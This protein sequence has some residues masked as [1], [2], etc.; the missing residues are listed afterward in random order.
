MDRH[1]DVDVTMTGRS[2]LG[3]GGLHERI[4]WSKF[5]N[6][7]F[8]LLDLFP[9]DFTL[10]LCA[11]LFV[12][13]TSFRPLTGVL[14]SNAAIRQSMLNIMNAC[15]QGLIPFQIGI[16]GAGSMGSEMAQ[17]FA[18]KGLV[19]SVFDVASAN[20]DALMNNLQTTDKVTPDVHERIHSFKDYK[21]F[22]D[23]LGG[24]DTKK[25]F[26]LSIK[27][28]SPADEVIKSLKEWLSSGDVILD[29]GNEWYRSTERRQEELIKLGVQYVGMGVR[30]VH[31]Q[32]QT[33]TLSI[34]HR[35]PG[36]TSPLVA[37]L[38]SAQVVTKRPSSPYCHFWK[39][40]L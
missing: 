2:Y 35:F 13:S 29:G 6:H 28:G 39:I 37:A 17:L 23:S 20:I 26:L 15:F 19:V 1:L 32:M 34:I 14:N 7:K 16:V 4:Q 3:A 24:K 22:V 31:V 21:T 30:N 9:L 38:P 33:I 12:L 36:V 8:I 25:L 11:R 18:E 40:S 27:H 5:F 10:V